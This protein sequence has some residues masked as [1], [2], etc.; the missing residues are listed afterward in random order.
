MT[1]QMQNQ[2]YNIAKLCSL[3]RLQ[4]VGQTGEDVHDTQAQVYRAKTSKTVWYRPAK[5]YI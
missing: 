5:M 2:M 4:G 1:E 3:S